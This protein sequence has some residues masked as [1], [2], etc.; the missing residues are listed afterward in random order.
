MPEIL[1]VLF[2]TA[3]KNSGN[4]REFKERMLKQIS[5]ENKS[6]I[7]LEFTKELLIHSGDFSLAELRETVKE[8]EIKKRERQKSKSEVIANLVREDSDLR[9]IPYQN[10]IKE[11]NKLEIRPRQIIARPRVL[12]IPETKLPPNLQYLKP[13]P[14]NVEINLEKLNPLIKDPLVR[15]IEC[16]GPGE[17]LVVMVPSPKYTNIILNKDEID[18]IIKTFEKESRI[19]S[20]EGMYNVVAGKLIFSAIISE[21]IG[22]KFT[23][24]K[25]NYAPVF[26]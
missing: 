7:L 25:M 14:V 21:A 3:K 2:K 6:L 10:T 18:G 1:K 19:P 5:Q 20:S 17:K 11:S 9:N 13:T 15:G 16:A 12:R 22:S 26:R 24:K 4:H 23:I 8:Q